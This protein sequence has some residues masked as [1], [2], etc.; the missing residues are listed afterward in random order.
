MPLSNFAISKATP[1][2]RAFIDALSVRYVKNFD[3]AKRREQDQAYA[4][5][6]AKVAAQL[7]NDLDAITLYGNVG[8]SWHSASGTLAQWGA[9]LGFPVA[10]SVNGQGHQVACHFPIT[11]A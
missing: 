3:A 4:D 9:T 6:M 7:P 5:A 2:E 1:K 8:N 11:P 10:Q